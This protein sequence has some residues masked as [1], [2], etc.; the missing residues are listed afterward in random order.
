[1]SPC[2]GPKLTII[3]IMTNVRVHLLPMWEAYNKI[4]VGLALFKD[5][6]LTTTYNYCKFF[7]SLLEISSLI[8]EMVCIISSKQFQY[9]ICLPFLRSNWLWISLT[10]EL[11][12]YIVAWRMSIMSKNNIIKFTKVEYGIYIAHSA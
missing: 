12:S 7:S 1:M 3:F 2:H 9:C 5:Y 11:F 6:Y 4:Q 10:V 8:T